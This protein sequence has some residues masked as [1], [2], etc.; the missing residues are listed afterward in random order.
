MTDASVA[1]TQSAVERFAEVYL[2]SVGCSIE[3]QGDNWRVTPDEDAETELI[4]ET[5][6][7]VIGDDAD[8]DN[9]LVRALHPESSFFQELL[10]EASERSPV[11]KVS[12]DT[13][14][15]SVEPPS[16][17]ENDT[18]EVTET[19]FTPFYDRTAV[20]ILF[21]VSIETVSEYQTELL[22]AAAIDL[23]SEEPLAKLEET[24]L[25]QTSLEKDSIKTG[26]TDI[27]RCDVEPLVRDAG[28]ILVDRI[29][30]RI[31]EIHQEASRAA[32]SEVE[33]Y[34]QMQEQRMEE[35][36][37]KHT[38]LS[39]KV[40]ELNVAIEQSAQ[41][42]RMELL[43]ER[44]EVKSA[45]KDIEEELAD[46]REARERGFPERQ[47]EI[48]SRHAI[49]VRV[50]PLTLTQ[51][52]YERGE[53]TFELTTGDESQS[54]TIGYGS[55]VGTTESIVCSNCGQNL[56]E[57]NPISAIKCGVQCSHCGD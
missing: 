36:E 35:L 38:T 31:D 13:S 57:E 52:E 4:T 9:D 12:V 43:K 2:P 49:D 6:S 41:S 50:K 40:D 33:E 20:V 46:L 8:A 11:G 10:T 44:K 51:V 42:E 32:D 54:V 26:R 3:K 22:R 25:E 48:R 19:N 23:R 34:R 1:I 39:S 53:V 18:V 15:T 7:I 27:E 45:Y 55:G 16:W 37:G 30:P 56:C 21:Q 5:V 17:I 47:R 14:R 28:E 24:F 29:Q